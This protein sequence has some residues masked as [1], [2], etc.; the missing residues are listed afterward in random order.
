MRQRRKNIEPLFSKE[1]KNYIFLYTIGF[2]FVGGC[3]FLLPIIYHKSLI[4]NDDCLA[5]YY[6]L[7]ILRK[8]VLKDF[9]YGIIQEHRIKWPIATYNLTGDNILTVFI[10]NEIF[11]WICC[12]FPTKMFESIFCAGL[13]LRMYLSG[14]TFAFC[15]VK[16]GYKKEFCVLG[17]LTYVSSAYFIITVVLQPPFLS[18]TYLFPLLVVG[19]DAIYEGRKEPILAAAICYS[20]VNSVYLTYY[21]SVAAGIYVVFAFATAKVSNKERVKCFFRVAAGYFKGFAF[22]AIFSL[23]QIYAILS[24]ERIGMGMKIEPEAIYGFD[25]ILSQLTRFFSLYEGQ[26]WTIIGFSAIGLFPFILSIYKR[27]PLP[28]LF[29][30]SMILI[31]IPAFGRI[32]GAGMTNN[33]WS[34]FL[35]FV[36]SLMVAEGLSDVIGSGKKEQIFLNIVSSLFLLFIIVLNVALPSMREPYNIVLV[37]TI[38]S[39]WNFIWKINIGWY[40]LLAVCAVSCI[41]CGI[42]RF[43]NGKARSLIDA[44]SVNHL[45]STYPDSA[46]ESISDSGFYRIDKSPYTDELSCNLPYWY[47]YNGISSFSN[48]LNSDTVKYFRSSGNTGMLQINKYTALGGKISDEA[49]AAVKY[50]LCEKGMTGSVPFGFKP[51]SESGNTLIYKNEY[52]LP[53]AFLYEEY[54][55]YAEYN[56]LTLAQQEELLLKSMVV[57]TDMRESRRSYNNLQSGTIAFKV[58][59]T[60]GLSKGDNGWIIDEEKATMTLEVY[61]KQRGEL[62]IELLNIEN[63]GTSNCRIEVSSKDNMIRTYAYGNQAVRG[64][65]QTFY[66]YCVGSCNSGFSEKLTI[67]VNSGKGMRIGDITCELRNLESYEKDI[68]ALSTNPLQKIEYNINGFSGEI[69]NE[70]SKNKYL[71]FSIP[72]SKGWECYIDGEKSELVKANLMYMATQINTGEHKVVMKYHPYGMKA[73]MMMSLLTILWQNFNAL[74]KT[75]K[76][77]NRKV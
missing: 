1:S 36:W 72:Y 38:I 69:L 55:S 17:A 52:V 8:N 68:K 32:A 14:L 4:V 43:G 66:C 30:V 27:K 73:G 40:S 61:P 42:L 7:L 70:S 16:K 18:M 24:S 12:L 46:Y 51:I 64:N 74:F 48:L 62:Y 33:R 37:L 76:T 21:L 47:G 3:L 41:A 44:G 5:N 2:A 9:V 11:D 65:N 34:F 25:K 28:W 39:I 23:P 67:S 59:D 56:S 31:N 13:V 10:G 15:S 63:S 6:E 49:L 50:F 71:F 29:I 77:M 26:E 58:L 45:I 20:F 75:M 22:S 53:I 54:T 57:N 60:E 19:I 35:A